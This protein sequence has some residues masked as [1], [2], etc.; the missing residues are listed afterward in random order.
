MQRRPSTGTGRPPPPTTAPGSPASFQRHPKAKPAQ[1]G[2]G[3]P[4]GTGRAERP[5]AG[6]S[7][8]RRPP[9][10]PLPAAAATAA[11]ASPPPPTTSYRLFGLAVAVEDDPGKDDHTT[12]CPALA[13]SA[14]ARLAGAARGEAARAPGSFALPPAALSIVRKSFDARARGVCFSYVVDVD[15]SAAVGPA[16]R[17]RKKSGWVEAAP[18]PED[19]AGLAWVGRGAA[20]GGAP[21]TSARWPGG[22]GGPPPAPRRRDPVIVVGAGPAGLFAA[23]RLARAGLPVTLL[24]RGRPVE[25]RGADI[26]ALFARRLLSPSSNLC[27]GEGGAGTWSDGKLATQIGKNSA[28]VRAVLATLVALGAPPSILTAGKPHLG[29]DRL[30]RLLRALRVSL[31][32]A[33]VT[34]L[35]DTEA[36]AFE[37]AAGRVTGVWAGPPREGGGE[38]AASTTTLLRASA[39]IFAPG[40]SAR[41]TWA[42]AAAAGASLEAK[43][44]AVGLRVEHPQALIDTAQYGELASLVARGKGPVPVADYRLACQAA[45]EQGSAGGGGAGAPPRGV[46]S[47]CMCP[48]GQ[49]VPTSTT[50][51]ELCING[52]SFSARGSPWANAAVVVGVGPEDWGWRGAGGEEVR[53]ASPATP[54]AALLATHPAFAGVR[55][56]RAV[57]R[58]AAVAGGGGLRA[59][60]QR[61][62]DYLGGEAGGAQP[63]A[64][65]PLPPSSYRLGVTPARLAGLYPPAVSAALRAGLA[66]FDRGLPG[67]AT[68]P[69]GLLHGVETRTS[70]PV[71]FVRGGA[72]EGGASR[73]PWGESPGLAGLFP[74][75]EGAGY[76]GGIVSAAVDGVRAAE[77]VIAGLVVGGGGVVAEW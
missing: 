65:T 72:G 12:V 22:Q 63:A 11:A 39:V 70:S 59:P 67:F 23:L 10:P 49:V 61:V 14:A 68:H 46:Y 73:T 56:Q 47:F 27:Y 30:V 20:D 19:A 36:A 17:P 29:T 1:P 16:V 43:P 42:A 13:A 15:T 66:R 28:Q 40:H 37:E 45:T 31:E 35:F 60:A 8:R 9:P 51:D 18:P 5:A 33:G 44:F 50:P 77:G 52:M 24:E 62:V 57:E 54:A 64:A 41:A 4:A 38:P 32:A 48:G 55:F 53:L 6:A 34:I 26:G 2:P 75:G 7:T 58:A 71:R 3:K 25:R 21:S 69:A 76:A 74:A